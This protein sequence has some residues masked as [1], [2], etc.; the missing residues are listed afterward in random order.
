MII[1]FLIMCVLAALVLLLYLFRPTNRV[2]LWVN[3]PGRNSMGQS[4][5]G[6]QFTVQPGPLPPDPDLEPDDDL[7]S[8]Q[9]SV[10]SIP[11]TRWTIRSP[12][13]PVP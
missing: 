12:A 9:P 1:V 4:G 11:L 2:N 10:N 3:I 6:G 5:G 7:G 8:F 13:T